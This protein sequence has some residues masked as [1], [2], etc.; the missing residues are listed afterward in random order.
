MNCSEYSMLFLPYNSPNMLGNYGYEPW[1]FG[2]YQYGG[3]SNSFY[4]GMPDLNQIT[5]YRP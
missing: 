2:N 3:Y 4:Y 5:S 1:R